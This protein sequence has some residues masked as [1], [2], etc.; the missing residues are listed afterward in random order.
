M[1]YTYYILFFM[2]GM[3]ACQS[4]KKVA[5]KEEKKVSQSQQTKD[6]PFKMYEMTEGALLMEEMYA[7]NLQLRSLIIEEKELGS[8]PESFSKLPYVALTDPTDRDDFYTEQAVK[9][10]SF[11][12]AIYESDQPKEAF[13]QMVQTCLECHY[14]KC[15]GPIPRIKTLLIP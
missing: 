4:D 13:N 11:Q 1:K 9:F 6:S 7:H 15:G 10:L 12:E 2:F 8:M 3:L 14:K 5:A